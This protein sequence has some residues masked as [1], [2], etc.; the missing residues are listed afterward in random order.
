V[1]YPSGQPY[2]IITCPEFLRVFPQ[3]FVEGVH[4]IYETGC[5]YC[6]SLI[7]YAIVQPT[8]PITA[9]AFQRKPG[10]FIGTPLNALDLG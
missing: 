7:R 4:P 1:Y 6:R 2:V 8:D 10:V 3:V 9:Q 5:V